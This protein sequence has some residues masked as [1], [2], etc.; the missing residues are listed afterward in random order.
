MLNSSKFNLQRSQHKPAC[1]QD[2]ELLT[3]KAIYSRRKTSVE[4]IIANETVP[5]DVYSDDSEPGRNL[6]D[7]LRRSDIDFVIIA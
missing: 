6:D 4:S 1:L 3:L 5:I 7:L 2:P